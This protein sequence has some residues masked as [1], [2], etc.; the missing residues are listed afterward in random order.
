MNLKP[1]SEFAGNER[2][3]LGIFGIDVGN[4]DTK[5]RHESFSSGY[6]KVKVINRLSSEYIAVTDKYGDPVYYTFSNKPFNL[7]VNKT[8]SEEM[9][10]ITLMAIAR[11]SVAR[12]VSINGEE[13]A[14][15]IGMPP[16]T[17]NQENIDAYYNYYM[18]RGKNIS[19]KYCCGENTYNFHFD[20][21]NVVVSAQCWGAAAQYPHLHRELNEVFLVDIGG[22]TT[23]VLHMSNGDI[24]GVPLSYNDGVN[25]MFATIAN[26]MTNETGIRFEAKNIKDAMMGKGEL[27]E[28]HLDRIK[29]LAYEWTKNIFSRMMTEGVE[30]R[31]TKVIT[32]GGGSLI[33]DNEIEK[34]AKRLEFAERLAIKDSKANATGY[35]LVAARA[36][37]RIKSK[38]VND[39]WRAFDVELLNKN[40]E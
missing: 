25:K 14:L 30:F 38:T 28:K 32:L 18:E 39:F 3:L 13:I 26:T 12:G 36:L 15:A 7:S 20:I 10:L 24:D 33:L 8:G 29:E 34:V 6:Q 19:Y 11:E 27:P 2:K 22:G 35:E 37:Y 5:T 23:D 31:L 9:F 4:H 16:G 21:G 40:V 17:Y 1:I